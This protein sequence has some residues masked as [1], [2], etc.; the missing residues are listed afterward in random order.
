MSR[1]VRNERKSEATERHIKVNEHHQTGKLIFFG[2]LAA[3][4]KTVVGLSFLLFS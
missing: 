1:A 4:S 3:E 2:R